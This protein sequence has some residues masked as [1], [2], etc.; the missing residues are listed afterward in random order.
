MRRARRFWYRHSPVF[1]Q[2]FDFFLWQFFW[3]R[4]GIHETDLHRAWF[5][6]KADQL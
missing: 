4:P 5:W 3:F 1:S 6:W 2:P